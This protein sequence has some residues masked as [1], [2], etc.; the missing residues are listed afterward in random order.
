MGVSWVQHSSFKDL[1]VAWRFFNGNDTPKNH[2]SVSEISAICLCLGGGMSNP[3]YFYFVQE[4][5]SEGTTGAP[6]GDFRI[7]RGLLMDVVS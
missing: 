4:A 5:V 1:V 2:T 7:Y 6:G 3:R